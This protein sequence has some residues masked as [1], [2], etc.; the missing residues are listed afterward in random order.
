MGFSVRRR[1][2]RRRGR[3]VTACRGEWPA[4]QVTTT[5]IA[6]QVLGAT[7]TMGQPGVAASSLKSLNH[8]LTVGGSTPFSCWPGNPPLLLLL[9]LS[10]SPPHPQQPPHQAHLRSHLV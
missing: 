7:T 5:T 3:S 2:G 6:A 8:K 9:Q 4:G 1:G 10:L